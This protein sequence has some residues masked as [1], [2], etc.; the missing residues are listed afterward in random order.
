MADLPELQVYGRPGCHLCE[1]MLEELVPLARGRARLVL[2]DVD[3]DPAWRAAYGERIP[4]LCLGGRELA[5][6]RIDP[7]AVLRALAAA[8][9]GD[10]GIPGTGPDRPAGGPC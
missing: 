1:L 2:R 8:A 9:A 3:D 6:H 5:V 7:G 4:V 10:D